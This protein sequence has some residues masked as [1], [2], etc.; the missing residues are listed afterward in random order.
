MR[1]ND[2]A[3]HPVGVLKSDK[4]RFH[5]IVFQRAP[6]HNDDDMSARRYKSLGHHT[7]GFGTFE[8][9]QKHIAANELWHPIGIVWSWSGD[10]IPAMTFWFGPIGDD[11]R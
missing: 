11:A 3:E 5:Q 8:D 7:E 9:A 4:G 10:G 6:L 1:D 2:F